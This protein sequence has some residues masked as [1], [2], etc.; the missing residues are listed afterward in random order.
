MPKESN[1]RRTTRVRQQRR[2]EQTIAGNT[3][4]T[5]TENRRATEPTTSSAT[6][7]TALSTEVLQLLLAQRS[8]SLSGSRDIL[9]RRLA[10]HDHTENSP[11]S[12][13]SDATPNNPTPQLSSE[14]LRLL[15]SDLVPLLR[16]A[17]ARENVSP[18]PP[19]QPPPTVNFPAPTP[20]LDLGNPA[21]VAALI[22]PQPSIP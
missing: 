14:S 22:T 3:G 18:T 21:Q 17:L 16:D 19:Y 4:A 1:K 11:V 8:L 6:N 5:S 9:L 7:Y 15:A 12:R 13:P 10:D 2:N 20:S